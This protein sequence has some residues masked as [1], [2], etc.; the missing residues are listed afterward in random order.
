M[1]GRLM[2]V[3]KAFYLLT[4]SGHPFPDGP[5]LKMGL[6]SYCNNWL[7]KQPLS[8]QLPGLHRLPKRWQAGES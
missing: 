3:G 5:V 1:T 7:T 4:M 6:S 2:K 8:R